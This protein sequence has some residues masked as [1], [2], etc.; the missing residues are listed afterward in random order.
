MA[1][2]PGVELCN[3]GVRY[4]GVAAIRDVDLDVRDGEFFSP[5]GPSSEKNSPSRT[6]SAASSS[7]PPVTC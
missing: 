3:V 7:Q 5:L 6:S 4:K 1:G 2:P